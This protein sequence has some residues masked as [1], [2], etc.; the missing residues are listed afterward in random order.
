MLQPSVTASSESSTEDGSV[1]GAQEQPNQEQLKEPYQI[2]NKEIHTQQVTITPT[3]PASMNETNITV[4]NEES[5]RDSD[6]TV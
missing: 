1:D 3:Q 2:A 6:L 5:S 4:M